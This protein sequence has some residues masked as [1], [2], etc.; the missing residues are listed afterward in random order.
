VR[1]VRQQPLYP[2]LVDWRARGLR[3]AR[4]LAAK[5]DRPAARQGHQAPMTA[6]SAP[7]PA[8][9]CLN[10]RCPYYFCAFI[11]FKALVTV[12][13]TLELLHFSK[14]PAAHG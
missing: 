5:P 7:Y 11:V 12:A 1:P 4:N 9:L 2:G 3:E 8:I 6:P 14:T 10:L 13:L